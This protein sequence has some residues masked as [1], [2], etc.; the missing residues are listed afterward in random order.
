MADKSNSRI[1]TESY[2]QVLQGVFLPTACVARLCTHV[3]RF[4]VLPVSLKRKVDRETE[5]YSHWRI[6]LYIRLRPCFRCEHVSA[7]HG[8][9]AI[10][11]SP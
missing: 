11:Q 6:V 9:Q 5:G 3:Y 8:F 7:F 10:Y 1:R 2:D 4:S